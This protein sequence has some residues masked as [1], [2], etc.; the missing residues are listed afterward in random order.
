MKIRRILADRL[1]FH[2]EQLLA[3]FITNFLIRSVETRPIR[4]YPRSISS[5]S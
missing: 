1:H 5:D 2:A 4:V 3:S